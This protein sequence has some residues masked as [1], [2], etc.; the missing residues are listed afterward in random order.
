MLQ[1]YMESKETILIFEAHSDDAV[2]GMGGTILLKST[3]QNI[4]LVTM[5]KGET[6]YTSLEEKDTIQE[7]RKNESL[8]TDIFLGVK[9]HIFLDTP[10]Q[11]LQNNLVNFHRVIE[12]IRKY[13]PTQIFTHKTPSKH[14]DHRNCHDLVTEA[15][16]K[17]SENVLPDLG[18]PVLVTKLYTF[19]VTDLFEF[20]NFIFDIGDIEPKLEVLQK[21]ESQMG[22]LPGIEDFVKGLALVRGYQGGFKY[23]EA[24]QKS[25]FMPT[26]I[27]FQP[28]P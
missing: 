23:G 5:T 22:V 15:W 4:V 28:K 3:T 26:P 8:A 9:E 13:R 27:R 11:D 21:F 16:W 24:F 10:C 25:D 14:R 1:S 20:P 7:R 12:I 19:E 2:I 17:A 6:G 18:D